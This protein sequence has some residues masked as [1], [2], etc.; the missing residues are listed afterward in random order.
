[1]IEDV[2]RHELRGRTFEADALRESVALLESNIRGGSSGNN[3]QTNEGE[4]S[5]IPDTRVSST[6]ARTNGVD[7]PTGRPGANQT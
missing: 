6:E 4:A 3:P 1:M 2:R 5:G 7:A